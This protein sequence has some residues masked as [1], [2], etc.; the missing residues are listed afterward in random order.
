MIDIVLYGD[1]DVEL[2]PEAHLHKPFKDILD[3][4][5]T[6]TKT[7]A[8][9]EFMYIFLTKDP[10]SSLSVYPPSTRISKAAVMV[11]GKEFKP[12]RKIQAAS[13][14]YE[15]MLKETSPTYI[16]WEAAKS[17]MDKL[18]SIMRSTDWGDDSPF[19]I[20][21]FSAYI[22]EI[23]AMASNLRSL[24]A[25]VKEEATAAPKLKAQQTVNYFEQ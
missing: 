3:R 20:K 4:D 6:V 13:D 25:K 22:K 14:Y 11:Y 19:T 2:S 8:R 24:E 15:Q 9:R 7:R 23:D 10:R 16:M 12:D 18:S 17:A 5:D 21:E 1:G